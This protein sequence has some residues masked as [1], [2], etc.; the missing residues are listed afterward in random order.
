MKI[1]EEHDWKK[2]II[3]IKVW[4]NT[5]T[6]SKIEELKLWCCSVSGWKR[7]EL[8][9][10]TDQE[11]KLKNRWAIVPAVIEW[12]KS[13][14]LFSKGNNKIKRRSIKERKQQ[15]KLIVSWI[16]LKFGF[17]FLPSSLQCGQ[18][19]KINYFTIQQKHVENNFNF[20]TQYSTF[21]VCFSITIVKL[22]FS[23]WLYNFHF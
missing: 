9:E 1:K 4:K 2:S 21:P 11:E 15:Q 5:Y 12:Y 20:S 17:S 3:V 10:W 22:I 14:L 6:K 19:G 16:N 7:I 18:P 8:S 13:T 23:S